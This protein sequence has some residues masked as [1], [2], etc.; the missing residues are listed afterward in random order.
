MKLIFILLRPGFERASRK[1]RDLAAKYNL[2]NPVA[3][4]Y[5]QAEHEG[6]WEMCADSFAWA[7][8]YS[9]VVRPIVSCSSHLGVRENCKRNS[10]VAGI[11]ML[12]F[13]STGA[14]R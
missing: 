7:L 8:F 14:S 10:V 4:N 2:G 6:W 11:K 13:D 1:A 3:G 5:F 12:D 9:S